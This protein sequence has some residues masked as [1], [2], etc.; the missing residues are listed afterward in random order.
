LWKLLN[1]Q[2]KL[3][4]QKRSLDGAADCF[5]GKSHQGLQYLW[6]KKKFSDCKKHT[7]LLS[8]SLTRPLTQ[9]NST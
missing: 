3:Q 8:P 4:F 6:W 7:H 9:K 1:A 2:R 5:V